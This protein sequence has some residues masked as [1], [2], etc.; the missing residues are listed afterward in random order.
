MQEMKILKTLSTRKHQ[1]AI[2]KSFLNK[3]PS[4]SVPRQWRNRTFCFEFFNF[5]AFTDFKFFPLKLYLL[6]CCYFFCKWYPWWEN[7]AFFQADSNSSKPSFT[8]VIPPP[9]VTGALHIGHALT[10]AIQD[11]IIHWRRMSGYN[12][13]WVPEMDHAGIATQV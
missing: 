12:T 10:A 5:T 9:N 2:R 6:I 13:L 3:W 8:I 1:L 11:T 4:N 7:S